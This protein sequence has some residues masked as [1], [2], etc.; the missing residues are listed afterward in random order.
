[1]SVLCENKAELLRKPAPWVIII[2][3][4]LGN[5]G[6]FCWYSYVSKVITDV[7]GFAPEHLSGIMMCAGLGMVFGNFV[8]GKL[9]D[10]YSPQAI[11]IA[12]QG[13]A[14]FALLMIFFLAHYPFLSLI[15]MF[16]CTSCLFA[17]SAPQQ[18]LIIRHSRGGEMLG[19]SFAQAGFNMGNA[20]GAYLGGIP[21]T[22]GLGYE[23]T[24]LPGV[25]L[26]LSG[27]AL[28]YWF[29]HNI[30]RHRPK[31]TVKAA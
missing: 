19:A 22:K 6:I 21:V 29:Y 9:A 24:A 7:S 30:G 26:S 2:S 3:I 13:F 25:V 20:V 28:L 12:T 4:M 23:Y 27:F 1:M 14:A 18:L 5:G 8:S 15:F 17:L 16:I 11:A 31:K 10:R